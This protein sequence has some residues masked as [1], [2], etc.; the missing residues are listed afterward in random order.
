ME[1]KKMKSSVWSSLTVP[2]SIWVFEA[3]TLR[4]YFS[5][6]L[7][8]F[9]FVACILLEEEERWPE[10]VW[11]FLFHWATKQHNCGHF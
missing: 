10:I 9:T 5:V 2:N 4:Y 8:Y 7:P 11:K 6:T 1:F 3:K